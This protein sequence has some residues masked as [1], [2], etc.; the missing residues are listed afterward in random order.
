MAIISPPAP[1]SVPLLFDST[2]RPNSENTTVITRPS[3]PRA[4]RSALKAASARESVESCGSW[5]LSWLPWVSKEPQSIVMT[6]TPRFA[7]RSVAASWRRC[8]RLEVG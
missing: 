3:M 6:F 5:L 7:D 1:W 2:R 8:E 4:V